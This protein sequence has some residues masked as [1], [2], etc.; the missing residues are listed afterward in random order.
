[1]SDKKQSYS[2]MIQHENRI[3]YIFSYVLPP[4]LFVLIFFITINVDAGPGGSDSIGV[5]MAVSFIYVLTHMLVYLPRRTKQ[6]DKKSSEGIFQKMGFKKM[7]IRDEVMYKNHKRY[8]EF[9]IFVVAL[10]IIMSLTLVLMLDHAVDGKTGGELTFEQRRAFTIIQSFFYSLPI[11]PGIMVYTYYLYKGPFSKY[12][13]L[14]LFFSM[15]CFKILR[16][17]D[18]ISEIEKTHYTIRGL[19]HYDTYLRRTLKISINNIEKFYTKLILTLSIQEYSGIILSKLENN[20]KLELLKYLTC[21]LK[22]HDDPNSVSAS[23]SRSL[24]SLLP[25]IASVIASLIAAGIVILFQN[26]PAFN[27]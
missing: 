17:F 19:N 20:D 11:V 26:L 6:S 4:I 9:F 15:G 22:S 24:K 12:S 27:P 10:S 7:I 5:S 21:L 14:H 1:M 25:F 3:S 13:D 16:D 23:T 18:D 2:N 8:V